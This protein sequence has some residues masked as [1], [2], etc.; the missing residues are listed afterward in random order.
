MGY[1]VSLRDG[2]IKQNKTMYSIEGYELGLACIVCIG[3]IV[4]KVWMYY[5]TNE[6]ETNDK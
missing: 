6:D 3:Y 4:G 2:Y 5:K 1:S